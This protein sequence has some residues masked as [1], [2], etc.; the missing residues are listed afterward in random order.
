MSSI[1][2]VTPLASFSSFGFHM[3]VAERA[4]LLF[5]RGKI[6]RSITTTAPANKVYRYCIQLKG[7]NGTSVPTHNQQQAVFKPGDRVWLK[8]PH[9]RCTTKYKVGR[10]T[11]ITSA[12]NI[13]VDGM[14]RHMKDLQPKAVEML[15]HTCRR[16]NTLIHI[17]IINIGRCCPLYALVLRQ[18]SINNCLHD[19]WCNNETKPHAA[20]AIPSSLK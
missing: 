6:V 16:H 15:F 11:G 3:P 7:I 1:K 12:Q 19:G 9:G 14:P 17:R 2:Q 20:Q 5:L 18:D 4:H 10:V 8:T 13:T